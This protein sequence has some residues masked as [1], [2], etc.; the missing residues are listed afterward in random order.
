MQASI[1]LLQN[2]RSLLAALANES[3][4]PS[5]NIEHHSYYRF[6]HHTQLGIFDR[7]S[8]PHVCPVAALVY[9]QIRTNMAGLANHLKFGKNAI[10][11]GDLSELMK[12]EMDFDALTVVQEHTPSELEAVFKRFNIAMP[13]NSEI[14]RV[15]DENFLV[16]NWWYGISDDIAFLCRHIQYAR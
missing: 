11:L 3:S 4:S 7:K 10:T 5:R 14:I 8:G 16:G 1:N 9:T 12:V 15:T 2:R 13:E 6:P